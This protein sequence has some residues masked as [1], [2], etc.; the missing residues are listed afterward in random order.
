M[1]INTLNTISD[2]INSFS[3]ALLILIAGTV[4]IGLIRPRLLRIVLK[5]FA[6][7]KYIIIG[8]IFL[9]LICGTI[10]TVSQSDHSTYESQNRPQPRSGSLVPLPQTQCRNS[11]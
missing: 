5:E 2:L 4:L 11:L 9:S 1:D 3:I 7:R 8:G 6:E 10:Y